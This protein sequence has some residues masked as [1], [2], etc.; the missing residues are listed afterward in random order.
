VIRLLL[1]LVVTAI[2][3]SACGGG[4]LA[5][6]HQN[7]VFYD[8]STIGG[9][10]GSRFEVHY[11][12]LDLAA[13]GALPSY[14]GVEVLDRNVRFSR[15]SNWLVRAASDRA[16][17]RFIQYL[18]PNEYLFGIYE[19]QELPN[20]RWADVLAR[21]EKGLKAN[22]AEIVHSGVPMAT[23][24]GQGRAYLIRRRIPAAKTPYINM[25]R[26]Y[27]IRAEHRIVLVQIIH[28][29]DGLAP[30]SAELRRAMDT[31]ALQ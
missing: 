16:G 26:E 17:E 1:S 9:D 15:P 13:K 10:L 14:R 31:L 6:A 27:L 21:Y 12:P 7:P 29:V 28:P 23:F 22:R 11:P 20:A 24:N 2:S 18:S 4:D 5:V 19:R 8:N 25:S 30:I 3:L